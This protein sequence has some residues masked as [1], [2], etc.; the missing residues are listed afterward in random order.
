MFINILWILI[1]V[2]AIVFLVITLNYKI[3]LTCLDYI[4]HFNNS[5]WISLW[6]GLTPARK[7]YCRHGKKTISTQHTKV[8][9]W[10]SIEKEDK[11]MPSPKRQKLDKDVLPRFTRS[12][13]KR[14][15]KNGH[16]KSFSLTEKLEVVEFAKLHGRTA[17]ARQY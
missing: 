12:I 9:S 7:L 5:S 2:M 13:R 14:R 10:L 11:H 16:C 3:I 17:A 8:P 6:S 4:F 15:K 1:T